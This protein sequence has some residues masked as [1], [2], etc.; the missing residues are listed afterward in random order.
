MH[1]SCILILSGFSEKSESA[2]LPEWQRAAYNNAAVKLTQYYCPATAP[3]FTQP[4]LGFLQA[5]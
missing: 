5:V 2:D 1:M 4:G 3:R